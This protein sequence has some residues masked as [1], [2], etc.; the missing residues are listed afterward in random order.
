MIRPKIKT[1]M[2][3]AELFTHLIMSL[4]PIIIQLLTIL[5]S[6]GAVVR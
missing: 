4:L 3:V 6:V 2:V 5:D 1:R